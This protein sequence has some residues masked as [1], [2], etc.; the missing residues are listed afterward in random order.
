MNKRFLNKDW[1]DFKGTAN[2]TKYF[3]RPLW[4][5]LFIL[6]GALLLGSAMKSSMMKL[7]DKAEALGPGTHMFTFSDN[8]KMTAEFFDILF[9]TGSVFGLL[10]FVLGYIASVWLSLSTVNKRLNSVWA[11]QK[12]WGWIFYIFFNT[13]VSIILIFK[14]G[15]HKP[16]G[17]KEFIHAHW[18]KG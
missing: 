18:R 11:D 12:V 5:L 4:G 10:L 9:T 17:A 8:I 16:E 15:V 1:W 7:I 6:P 14:N 13:A 2:G 3:L